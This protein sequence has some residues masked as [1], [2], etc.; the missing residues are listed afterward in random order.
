MG[1]YS[2]EEFA[3]EAEGKVN[4]KITIVYDFS[5]L[6]LDE[7]NKVNLTEHVEISKGYDDTYSLESVLKLMDGYNYTEFK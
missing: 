4:K 6:I 2:I 7:N 1:V 3:G 5:N